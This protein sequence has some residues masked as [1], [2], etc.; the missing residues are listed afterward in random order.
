VLR[1]L[2]DWVRKG[3]APPHI[4]NITVDDGKPVLDPFGNVTGGIRSPYVDVPTSTWFSN[5][6]GPSFCRIAGYELP[7]SAARLHEL[8]ASP[9]SYMDAVIANVKE[10]VRSRQLVQEDAD[11]LVTEAK[12]AS[13]TLFAPR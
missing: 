12:T 7:L 9:A 2:D 1:N 3:I 13:K 10:L 4:D 6:T 11:W 8:Y 5:A